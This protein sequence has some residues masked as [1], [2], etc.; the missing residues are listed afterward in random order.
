MIFRCI[1]GSPTF[2]S[3]QGAPASLI[4]AGDSLERCGRGTPARE[5][6]EGNSTVPGK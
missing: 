2:F 6:K 1:A 5:K 4:Q 3:I